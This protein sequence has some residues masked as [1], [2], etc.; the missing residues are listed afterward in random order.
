[1]INAF[2]NKRGE[3]YIDI[4]VSV[5]VSMMV[6]V[7]S[8]NVF[9][10]LTVKQD[11]DYFAKEMLDTATSNGSVQID[12][13]KRYDELCLDTGLSPDI[14]WDADYYNLSDGTVQLSDTITVTVTY[15]TYLKGFGAIKI[16]I[17]LTARQSG[18]SRKYWK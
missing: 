14:S 16:P 6:L 5:L 13:T 9:S 3:G 2:K 7:I 1:M 10:F 15:K 11:I 4:V 17:T 12:T 8:L 18:I